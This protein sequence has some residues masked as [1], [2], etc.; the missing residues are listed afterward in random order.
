MSN[1]RICVIA[2]AFLVWATLGLQ[3]IVDMSQGKTMFGALWHQMRYF[4]NL[5]V[6]TM[7][8]VLTVIAVRGW[9]GS[10]LPAAVTVWMLIVGLVYHTLLSATHHP[11]GWDVLV[12]IMQHSVLPIAMLAL[13][14]GFAPKSGLRFWDAFTWLACPVLYVSYVLIRGA[15]DGV[16]PY[17]FVDPVK[18]GWPGVAGFVVGLGALFFLAGAALVM[19]AWFQVRRAA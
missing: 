16:Y 17:F 3:I 5:M 10:S 18:T 7:A 4:T 14:I 12:N 1:D 15:F 2:L 9:R 13:W 6:F 19:A 8:V 11:E